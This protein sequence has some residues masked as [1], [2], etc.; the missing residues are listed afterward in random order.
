MAK[1][2]KKPSKPEASYRI[3]MDPEPPVGA[4]VYYMNAKGQVCRPI[5]SSMY[6]WTG[7][8]TWYLRKAK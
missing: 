8:S 3:A 7:A 1:K 6:T 4:K 5:E 2:T